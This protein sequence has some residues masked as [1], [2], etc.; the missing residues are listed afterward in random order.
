MNWKRNNDMKNDIIEKNYFEVKLLN[1]NQKG[2]S[3]YVGKMFCDTFLDIYTVEPTE[4]DMNIQAS[5]A[6][7]FKDDEEYYN[8]LINDDKKSIDNKAFQ[9][10]EDK[11]RVK[12][13]AEFL[14]EEEFA[15][16]PNTIIV[17]CDLANDFLNEDINNF[18]T[19]LS[20]ENEEIF[21]YPFLENI[22]GNTSLYIPHRKNTL[23]VID[24]QHRV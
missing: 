1:L 16:F 2:K 6:S 22:D 8:F 24:G 21:N 12:E 13:I 5:L 15:L 10:K 18:Q 19:F 17:T 23:L 3:F 9:R 4:Y 7:K 11:R 20:R 14:S